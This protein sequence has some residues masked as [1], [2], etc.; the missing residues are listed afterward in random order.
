MSAPYFRR[1]G[2]KLLERID[3]PRSVGFFTARQAEEKEMRLVTGSV[4]NLSLYWLVDESDGVIADA[5]FQVFG[6]PLLIAAAEIACELAL[7][8][9]YD[10]ASRITEELIDRHVRDRKDERAFPEEAAPF[11]REVI[12]ALQQAVHQC[13]DIPFAVVYESTPIQKSEK[14]ESLV[15]WDEFPEATQKQLIMELIDREVRPYI[16]LDAGGVEV[17]SVTEN[18][19]VGIVYQGACTSCP[20]SQG[21]TLTAIQEILRAKIHPDIVLKIIS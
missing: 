1:Y 16:E 21:S 11:L 17:V 14:G 5:L 15:G 20:S 13:L 8:K 6:P 7:R 12:S 10:Q 19:E 3:R 4:K 2:K 18:R 9:T